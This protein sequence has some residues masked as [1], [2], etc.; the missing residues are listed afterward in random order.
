MTGKVGLASEKMKEICDNL[1]CQE[2][3]DMVLK[4]FDL[5]TLAD[6]LKNDDTTAIE[7]KAKDGNWHLARFI[8]KI[9]MK[10]AGQ[11]MFVCDTHNQRNKTQR[12]KPCT[13]GRTCKKRK[14]SKN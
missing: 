14:R 5:S 11:F 3:Y 1:V 13:N 12:R 4:F 6:R 8:V 10:K 7:Y 9:R 2:H